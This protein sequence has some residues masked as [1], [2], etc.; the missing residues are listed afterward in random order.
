MKMLCITCPLPPPLNNAYFTDRR[1]VRRVLSAAGRQYKNLIKQHVGRT[2]FAQAERPK[3]TR[4]AMTYVLYFP[5]NR[6]TDLSNRPKLLEDAL[7]EACSF[8]DS[9][10]DKI[11]IARGGIDKLNPRCDV[12]IEIL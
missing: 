12:M 6:R 1:N 9:A 2:Q 11:V 3:G 5:D 4:Y 10:V 7:A 8:D